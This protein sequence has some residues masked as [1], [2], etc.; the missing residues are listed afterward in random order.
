MA[1]QGVVRQL[2]DLAKD[3]QN[4]EKIVKDQ[5]CLPGLVLFLDNDDPIVVST[6]LEAIQYLSESAV[7]RPLM[8][9]ELGML[10]SLEA[11]TNN[12]ESDTRSKNLARSIH[13]RLTAPPTPGPLK[14]S[15]NPNIPKGSR[16]GGMHPGSKFFVGTS[17]KKKSKI[18]TLQI[19]GLMNIECRRSCEEE[20]LKVKGVVSFT[21]DL[22][23]KRCELR[24]RIDM[25]PE[26]LIAAISRTETMSAEQVVKNEHGEEVILS[27]GA[28]PAMANKE[29]SH[30]SLPD[31]LPEDNSPIRGCHNKAIKNID[32]G[33]EERRGSWIGAA[34]SFISTNFYW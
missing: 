10:V 3:P 15:S 13:N 34:A 17:K 24:T 4:R 32:Q 33:D 30:H 1:V 28:N 31:Y 11:I 21:F 14:E 29:N 25:K 22:L 18:L 16:G 5:G 2:R 9:K 6:A 8:K 23:K 19:N 12:A 26:V 20:L 27:F 7:N